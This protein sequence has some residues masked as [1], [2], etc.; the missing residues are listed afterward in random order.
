MLMCNQV[1]LLLQAEKL[2]HQNFI[3]NYQSF[4]VESYLKSGE[5]ILEAGEALDEFHLLLLARRQR[6]LDVLKLSLEGFTI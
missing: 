6:L 4:K 1:D 5:V 2:L 3:L